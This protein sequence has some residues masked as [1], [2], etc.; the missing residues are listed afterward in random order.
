MVKEIYEIGEKIEIGV[1]PKF[2][3]ALTIREERFG[4]PKKSMKI[5]KVE[6]P[7]NLDDNEVLIKM[8]T[9]GVN[10]NV[11]FAGNGKPLNVIQNCKKLDNDDRDYLFQEVMGQELFGKLEIK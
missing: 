5:E 3:Y 2:M 9:A 4:E 11:I 8:V 10:H 6:V 7:S 1:I